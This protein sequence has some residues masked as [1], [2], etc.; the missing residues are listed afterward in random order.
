MSKINNQ[1]DKPEKLTPQDSGRK[2]ISHPE[3]EEDAVLKPED[4]DYTEEEAD[5]R[6]PAKTKEE[7]EQPVT[8][9]K[10]PPKDV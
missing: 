3:D 1:S 9:V 7:G 2:H 4:M 5:F 6:D 10:T 8:P